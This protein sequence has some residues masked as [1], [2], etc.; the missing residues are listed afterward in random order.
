MQ[1]EYIFVI[2]FC[3]VEA[4]HIFTLFFLIAKSKNVKITAGDVVDS[5]YKSLKTILPAIGIKNVNDIFVYIEEIKDIF[6]PIDK[7]KEEK[8]VQ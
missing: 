5:A 1:K 2:I 6:K 8:P 7:E 4:F 3:V